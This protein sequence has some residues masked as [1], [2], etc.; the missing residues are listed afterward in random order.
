MTTY[1]ANIYANGTAVLSITGN[2]LDKLT[3]GLLDKL[4][5][6]Y[7]GATASIAVNTSGKVIQTFRKVAKE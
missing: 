4:E 3:A 2:D 5:N 6:E 7:N 1:T